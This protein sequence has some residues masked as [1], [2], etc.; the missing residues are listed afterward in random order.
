MPSRDRRKSG[1]EVVMK[2]GIMLWRSVIDAIDG[3]RANRLRERRFLRS[4][5]DGCVVGVRM[6][7]V[8]TMSSG[9][10]RTPAMPAAATA[11]PNEARG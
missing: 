3:G 9:A 4:E 6:S 1:A 11:T 2:V 10:R 7:F 5:R 8:R